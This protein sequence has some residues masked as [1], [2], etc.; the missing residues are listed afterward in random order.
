MLIEVEILV[1]LNQ[2]CPTFSPF[3]TCGDKQN[4]MTFIFKEVSE[5][6]FSTSELLKTLFAFKNQQ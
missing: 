5:C 3:A 2:R 1:T 6:K 4:F